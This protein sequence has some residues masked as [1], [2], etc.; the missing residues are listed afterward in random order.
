MC[1]VIKPKGF[2]KPSLTCH[3]PMRHHSRTCYPLPLPSSFPTFNFD[4]LSLISCSQAQIFVFVKLWRWWWLT[5]M[6]LSRW[7]LV[8]LLEAFNG[9]FFVCVDG[10]LH[11]SA[12]FY[13]TFIVMLLMRIRSYYSSIVH[14]ICH[15]SLMHLFLLFFCCTRTCSCC[16]SIVHLLMLCFCCLH[17]YS[18]YTQVVHLFLLFLCCTCIYSC[19]VF[20]AHALILVGPFYA[21]ILIALLFIF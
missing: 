14:L 9:N 6:E 3:S 13:N 8:L 11:R 17:T 19:Y 12:L 4:F 18:C 21:F 5:I 16:A 15:A 7:L 10:G 1:F 2:V 20:V